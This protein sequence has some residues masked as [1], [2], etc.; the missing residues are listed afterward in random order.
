MLLQT[1]IRLPDQK[2]PRFDPVH[3]PNLQHSPKRTIE[4]GFSTETNIPHSPA[5]LHN[6]TSTSPFDIN[7]KVKAKQSAKMATCEAAVKRAFELP[8]SSDVPTK[9]ANGTAPTPTTTTDTKAMRVRPAEALACLPTTEQQRE[10]RSANRSASGKRQEQQQQPLTQIKEDRR[11]PPLS[12]PS[13]SPPPASQSELTQQNGK[14]PSA[15]SPQPKGKTKKS[16][17]KKGD[18]MNSSIDD[19]F[20]P[21]DIDLDSTEMDETEREVEYF[22]RFCL[23]SARQTRQRLSINWSNFS[24]KKATFAAH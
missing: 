11:G 7:G 20:L 13:P 16:K 2:E 21:K 9:V 1:L 19:V 14:P 8:K 24:L 22:K 18:K 6:G 15:E 10:E 12:N 4:K 3:R 17:K 5:P 23:D